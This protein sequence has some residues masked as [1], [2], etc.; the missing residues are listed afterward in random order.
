M[1]WPMKWEWIRPIMVVAEVVVVVAV[2]N[3]EIFGADISVVVSL[4][5]AE[6]AHIQMV[7]LVVAA[8]VAGGVV[9]PEPAIR[10]VALAIS[11]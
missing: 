6:E 3:L 4:A 7:V 9:I 1:K 10:V 11:L 5:V 2:D 8:L